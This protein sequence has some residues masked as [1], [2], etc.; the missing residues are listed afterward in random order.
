MTKIIKIKVG[1][2]FVKGIGY[3]VFTKAYERVSK[4]GVS[5]FERTEPVFVNEVE[6]NPTVEK[7]VVV[8]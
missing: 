6:A 8:K 3:S 1:D 2:V 7:E 4:S 5:Y